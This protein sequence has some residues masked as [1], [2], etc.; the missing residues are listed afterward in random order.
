MCL[1]HPQNIPP[2]TGLWKRCFPGKQS[3][4]PKGFRTA[5]LINYYLLLCGCPW[6]HTSSSHLRNSFLYFPM[7]IFP[8]I[9]SLSHSFFHFPLYF[10]SMLIL[11]FLICADAH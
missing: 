3:L 9:K 10:L 4:V 7:K 6:L 2:H 1:N 5:A 11:L 8:M